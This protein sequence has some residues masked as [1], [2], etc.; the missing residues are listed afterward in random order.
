MVWPFLR[1]PLGAPV[2]L[3]GRAQRWQVL[4]ALDLLGQLGQ[5]ERWKHLRS[6]N[7][8]TTSWLI[9]SFDTLLKIA[10]RFSSVVVITSS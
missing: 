6:T 10:K 5:N 3:T 4:G 1:W 2:H 8:A 9:V 7:T